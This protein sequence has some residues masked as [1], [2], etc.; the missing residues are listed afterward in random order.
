MLQAQRFAA[1]AVV[2]IYNWQSSSLVPFPT[3]GIM[4]CAVQSLKQM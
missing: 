3:A 2:N 4:A 1:T